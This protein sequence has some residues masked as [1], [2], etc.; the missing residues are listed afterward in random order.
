MSSYV[1]V[2]DT[3]VSIFPAK[4]SLKTVFGLESTVNAASSL[5]LKFN[6]PFLDEYWYLGTIIN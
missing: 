1:A 4:K 2:V 6:H 3:A 5:L